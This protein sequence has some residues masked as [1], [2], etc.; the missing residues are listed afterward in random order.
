[1][2]RAT[3][4]KKQSANTAQT[5]VVQGPKF[6]MRCPGCL[7]MQPWR[8]AKWEC[9]PTD[10]LVAHMCPHGKPCIEECKHGRRMHES[11]RLTGGDQPQVLGCDGGAPCLSTSA[12][13]KECADIRY[14]VWQKLSG[15]FA[16]SEATE[17]HQDKAKI[18][19]PLLHKCIVCAEIK[20]QGGTGCPHQ[21]FTSSGH[22]E[23]LLKMDGRC[24]WCTFEK[25]PPWCAGATNGDVETFILAMSDD[26]RATAIDEARATH[27]KLLVEQEAKHAADVKVAL[28]LIQEEQAAKASGHEQGT[29]NTSNTPSGAPQ[30]R[31]PM[32]QQPQQ[33]GV[34]RGQPR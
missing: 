30:R 27:A 20:R 16:R 8:A 14:F 23:S 24:Q 3:T 34:R 9:L 19:G 26:K 13:C 17:K 28:R 12:P 29:P 21:R 10:R 25:P 15:V 7:T 22:G 32:Q 11:Y 31:P 4:N 18:L 33:N 2:A 5:L 1:M 6:T